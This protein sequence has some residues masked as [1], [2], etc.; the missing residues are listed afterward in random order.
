MKKAQERIWVT[1]NMSDGLLTLW[2]ILLDVE[3]QIDQ[4]LEP[5]F[6]F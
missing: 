3:V 4:N 5:A 2:D 6:K 1:G